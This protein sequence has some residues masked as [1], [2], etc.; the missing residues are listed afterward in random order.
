MAAISGPPRGPAGE[1]DRV[2]E[3]QTGLTEHVVGLA[4]HDLVSHP[5]HPVPLAG[6]HR[7]RSD[8]HQE[9]SLAAALAEAGGQLDAAPPDDERVT[10]I[11]VGRVVRE[12]HARPDLGR[13]ESVGMGDVE[14]APDDGGPFAET[15]GRPERTALRDHRVR[16]VLD[17]V[18]PLERRKDRLGQLDGSGWDATDE[19]RPRQLGHEDGV[20]GRPL[21]IRE[22]LG[23][24]LERRQGG[25]APVDVEHAPT[26]V[27]DRARDRRPVA[28]LAPQLDR[29]FEELL[30]LIALIGGSGGKPGPFE[31]VGLFGRIGRHVDRLTEEDDRLRLCPECDGAVRCA[32]QGDP[33]LR[34]EGVLL[35]TRRGVV[36]GGEIVGGEC[37]GELVG[38]EGLEEPG[39]GDMPGLAVGAGQLAVGD[40]ADEPLHERVLAALG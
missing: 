6:R 27:S 5:Q 37:A 35:G 29:P 39:R 2:H 40:L 30:G 19:A 10:R 12:V 24:G 38:L 15:P 4:A 3:E 8:V 21:E 36:A 1:D 22:L 26:E 16:D 32:P 17:Q 11:L 31:Q 20:L 23:G 28:E 7:H 33:G 14:P 13:A 25:I 34:S 18:E 9:T